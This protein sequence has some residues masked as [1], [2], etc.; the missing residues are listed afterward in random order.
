MAADGLPRENTAS[1]GD[2]DLQDEQDQEEAAKSKQ[3]HIQQ[4]QF[5]AAAG[6]LVVGD[7]VPEGSTAVLLGGQA[8]GQQP[9]ETG[10]APQAEQDADGVRHQRHP[11]QCG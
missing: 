3:N 6:Q 8:S 10:H 7:D 4:T 9:A 2:T 11:H 5:L 1:D